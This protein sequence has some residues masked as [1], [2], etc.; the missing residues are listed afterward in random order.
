[1]DL[2][3]LGNYDRAY[4]LSSLPAAQL[5]TPL[6]SVALA[7]LSRLKQDKKLFLTYYTKAVSMVAFLGSILTVVLMLTAQD[8]VRRFWTG[9]DRSGQDIIGIITGD[10]SNAR[11]WNIPLAPSF[12][13]DTEQMVALEYFLIHFYC[14][15]LHYCFAIWRCSYGYCL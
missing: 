1:M 4:H 8:L 11:L 10:S 7:T 3:I 15:C 9:M 2:E 12:A 5:L 14:N 6:H 13:C